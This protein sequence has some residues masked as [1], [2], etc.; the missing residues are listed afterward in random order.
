MY[1]VF[2]QTESQIEL[3]RTFEASLAIY[4]DYWVEYRGV[5]QWVQI[6]VNPTIKPLFEKLLTSA[7]MKYSISISD[8]GSLVKN[9]ISLNSANKAEANADFDYGKYHTLDEI[10]HWMNDLEQQYPKM[11][12]VFNV[13]RSYQKRDIYAMRI[14]VPNAS[15]KPAIWLDGGIHAR[16]W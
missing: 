11:V 7:D 13:S 15:N 8:V 6:M 9:Q 4:L 3:I 2:I 14:S 1:K 16:E 5:N 10:N 12:T